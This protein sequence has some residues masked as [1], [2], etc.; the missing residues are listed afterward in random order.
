MTDIQ[1]LA[2][3]FPVVMVMLVIAVVTL[4][5]RFNQAEIKRELSAAQAAMPSGYTGTMTL[6]QGDIKKLLIEIS[7]TTKRRAG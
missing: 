5:E 2:L 1:I 6:E 4:E 3:C 7:D